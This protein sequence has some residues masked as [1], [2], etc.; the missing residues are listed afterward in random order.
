MT[1]SILAGSMVL[2]TLTAS[3]QT[4]GGEQ[5]FVFYFSLGVVVFLLFVLLFLLYFLSTFL[6]QLKQD[7]GENLV[8]SSFWESKTVTAQGRELTE[9]ELLSIH[10]YDG[11]RELDNNLPPWWVAMFWVTIVFG[12]A[13]LFNYH[14]LNTG[15]L[16]EKEYNIEMATA[17]EQKKKLE[18][19]GLA[20]INENSVTALKDKANL[21]KGLT[22]FTQNC[23]ACH[24]KSAEGG[25]GPNLTDD[26]WLHGGGIKN[27][28]KT[29]KYGVPEKGMIPWQNQLK[30]DQIQEVAS[31]ILS[32][33]GS[34]P[35][36]GKAPQGEVYKE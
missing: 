35:A 33:H 23:A 34:N 24:G 12:I 19:A 29:V 9:E 16:Q 28:F 20:G 32:L 1:R 4:T 3:A 13:Y 10:E 31:Y 5:G 14:L 22:I 25:V 17:A 15:D 8:H 18:D 36:N 27:V 11:I 2:S 7:R 26:Y 30:P 6:K 21:E